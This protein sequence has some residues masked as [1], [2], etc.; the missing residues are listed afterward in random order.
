MIKKIIWAMLLIVSCR[1]EVLALETQTHQMLNAYISNVA[2]PDG[3]NLDSYLKKNLGLSDGI[4]EVVSANLSVWEWLRDGGEYEDVPAWHLKYVRSVNHFYA[5]ISNKGLKGTA[6][7]S[8]QWALMPKGTQNVGGY[9]SWFD[10]RDYFYQALTGTNKAIR[11]D[12]YGK[13]FRSLGQLTHLVQD[14]S[15][16]AH[17]RDDAHVLT[18]SALGNYQYYEKWVKANADIGG[19]SAHPVFFDLNALSKAN[20]LGSVPV[21]NLFDTNTFTGINPNVST[22]RNIGLSEYTNPNF[23][24]DNTMF[25]PDYLYPG[26]NW[27][28]VWTD[29]T[30]N[31]KYLKK[32]YEGDP[33]NHLAAVSWLY[34]YRLVYFP[35]G[36]QYLPVGVDP[37]C[38]SEYAS[39]LIPYAVGYSAGLIN[40]PVA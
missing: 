31:R 2:T 16:P 13:T 21:A 22:M 38:H 26:K 23:L 40:S 1:S 14:L 30:V 28:E 36:D 8:L 34:W 3:F 33:V 37:Q 35:Q 19:L 11:D 5:P 12:Y 6:N 9:Y 7:S 25:T 32:L 17:V 24:S 18:I 20:S 4:R 39:K 15:V 29:S 27:L 10:A